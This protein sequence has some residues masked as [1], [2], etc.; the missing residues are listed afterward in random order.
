MERRNYF[1]ILSLEFDPPVSNKAVIKKAIDTWA[2]NAQGLISN[3]DANQTIKNEFALRADMEAVLSE[4]KSRN[5]EARALKDKRVAQL[6]QLIEIMRT[7]E[8]GTLEVTQPQIRN[9]S[10]KLRLNT[11]TVS[12]TYTKKGFVVQKPAKGINLKDVFIAKT[13][14]DKITD[15]LNK[16]HGMSFH[17]FNWT[18]KVTNL[19]DLACFYSGGSD[20][21]L[22]AFRRR[23]TSELLNIMNDGGVKFATDMSDQGHVLQILF[24]T[25][26]SQIFNSEENR[27]KYSQTLEREKLSS[28]FALLKTAP[29][30]FKKDRYFAE[31]CIRTI[32]KHFP[33]YNLALALYNTEAGLLQ[34]PYE[35]IEAFIR[36]VCG[37]C[38]SPAEFRTHEDAQRGKCAVCGAKLYIKCPKC[39][40]SAPAAAD[41][42][43]CGFQISEM[44]FFEDYFRAAEFALDELDLSEAH[45]QYENAAVAYPGHP[46]LPG[47]LS[48]IDKAEDV[49]LKY[50]GELTRLIDQGMLNAAQAELARV[51]ASM[52]KLKLDSHRK[53][54]SDGLTIAQNRM[55]P[56]GASPAD[57]ANRCID[58]LQ[59]VKDFQPAIDVLRMFPPRPPINL[60]A[61]ARDHGGLTCH[62][63]WG[64]AG[65]K[66]VRYQ[67]VRKRDGM[68]QSHSDGDV[69]AR[70]LTALEF[71][72]TTL[73]PG[74]S[75]GYAVFANRYG[76]YSAPA[77]CEVENFSELDT[78]T[79]R[80][81]AKDGVCHFSWVLP[82]NC[83]GVR[84]LR[85]TNAIPTP[86]LSSDV[87]V[88]AE[89]AKA[90]FDDVSVTNGTDYGY[91][92]QC[93][94]P[95]QNGFKF[96]SG[97]TTLLHPDAPPVSIR[98]VSSRVEG[99]SVTVRWFSPD[100]VQR[101][102]VVRE[103]L[104]P[105]ISGIKGQILPSSEINA[106]FS[107]GRFF[108]QVPSSA[109]HCQF[110][111]PANSVVTL[112][113]ITFS[114]SQGIV[115]EVF[116]A[117]SVERC[118]LDKSGTKIEGDRLLISLSN[119]PKHLE[120]IFYSCARKIDNRIPWGTIDDAKNQLMS[121][122]SVADYTRDGIIVVDHPPQDDLYIT[123]I[124][125][126]RMADGS[127]VYSEPSKQR[128]NNKPKQRITYQMVWNSSFWGPKTR[129][130]KLVV[131]TSAPETPRMQLVC[132]N[133]GHIP[134]RLTDPANRVLLT[135]AESD[136]GFRSG[137]YT[138]CFEDG[139]WSGI[140]KNAELRLMLQDDDLADYEILPDNLKSLKV[141]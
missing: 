90:N 131:K 33:D 60:R 5:L 2:K 68:P 86:Q 63:S 56:P 31:S 133:D 122:V 127:I 135:I 73:Q 37:S 34:D 93:V 123:I 39:G 36:V 58:I 24:S 61:T 110:D 44:R 49:K 52:P 109:N 87:K 65:D 11:D 120:R 28:F 53:K 102:V 38:N 42:C 72:D 62:L 12:D 45:K 113:V 66:G 82:A 106:L 80:A 96:S 7:G 104:S 71:K 20:G 79:I 117:S 101:N 10:Q 124:G 100:S 103:V 59:T 137:E 116:Q 30:D 138:H 78:K 54:I 27:K 3:G 98:N 115:S 1:E 125:R 40:K 141:P 77:V 136:T 75:Y 121:A 118:E 13:T 81:Y 48:R 85:R 19:F 29:E 112:A 91:R 41:R 88:V 51:Q 15:H 132:R 4:A 114:G 57:R 129:N 9:V 70:D 35:P 18:S 50:L 130:A 32:Q 105:A 97:W 128:I 47:L 67:V 46:N 21:D 134:M 83:V 8:T 43:S 23:K 17:Q 69:L 26:S 25:G 74:I 140:S 119:L 107:S 6:E 64:A 95:Y 139:D 99:R 84:I 89:R 126:Y 108:A 16:M 14:A 55:P 94:Y 111:I 76:T 22:M 92:L